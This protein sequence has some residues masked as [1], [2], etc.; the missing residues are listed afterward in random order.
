M[1]VPER[2]ARWLRALADQ[3]ELGVYS[4]AEMNDERVSI[5]EKRPDGSVVRHWT[6]ERVITLRLQE[7]GKYFT[8]QNTESHKEAQHVASSSGRAAPH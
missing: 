4:Y 7:A 3:V 1:L 5:A 8:P 6:G 2:V